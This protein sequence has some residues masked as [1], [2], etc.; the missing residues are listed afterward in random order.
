VGNRLDFVC[1]DILS[2]TVMQARLPEVLLIAVL[3]EVTLMKL[4]AP[5]GAQLAF[6]ARSQDAEP[7]F[8]VNRTDGFLRQFEFPKSKAQNVKLQT[9][10]SLAIG[11]LSIIFPIDEQH[12]LNVRAFFVTIQQLQIWES[13]HGLTLKRIFTGSVMVKLEYCQLVHWRAIWNRV[14]VTIVAFFCF[15][16]VSPANAIGLICQDT[17]EKLYCEYQPPEELAN[18]KTIVL[19]SGDE[20][21]RSEELM[22]MLGKLLS[23][24]HGFHCFVIFP[25]D[26]KTGEIDPNNQSNLP[27]LHLL[28]K[29]DLIIM[30]WRFRNPPDEEMKHFVDYYESGRPIIALRTSTHAFN[31]KPESKYHDYS[32]N[33][34]K[35]LGGFGQQ[36]LGETWVSH[37]GGHGTESTRGIVVE[38]HRDHPIL[39]GVKDVWGPSDVYGIR[40]LPADATVI[41]E[42]QILSG[43]KPESEPVAD[44]RNNPMMPLVWFRELSA[45]DRDIVQ[46]VVTTTMGAATD[47]EVG[48]LTRLIVNASHWCLDLED[49]I[50]P[51]SNMRPV[52][53]FQPSPFGFNTFVKGKKTSDHNLKASPNR[54]DDENDG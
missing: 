10:I 1:F 36:V 47:F 32:F 35:W 48:D 18:G 34:K 50:R 15:V 4:S 31:F 42:G 23:Q 8:L 2:A 51:D 19:L 11:R 25:I 49:S 6:R 9:L 26:P 44:D 45:P 41:M 28:Q 16:L 20:E 52:D 22:P 17:E 7:I 5:S 38:Q 29:A 13:T 12:G 27:G 40:K 33:S 14:L 53:P 24:R 30:A 43:M 39:R 37:H 54:P 21:Y 46:R 3:A